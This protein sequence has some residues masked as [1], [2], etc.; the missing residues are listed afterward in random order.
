M[1]LIHSAHLSMYQSVSLYMYL[2]I[3]LRIYLYNTG[4]KNENRER[5]IILLYTMYNVPLYQVY[6]LLSFILLLELR[7]TW[8]AFTFHWFTNCCTI[9]LLLYFRTIKKKIISTTEIYKCKKCIHAV[10]FISSFSARRPR[11]VFVNEHCIRIQDK[12]WQQLLK[13]S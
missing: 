3:Y 5:I 2:Y 11:I 9:V 7:R 13:S 1:H 4:N 8:Y 10:V 6:L 12:W